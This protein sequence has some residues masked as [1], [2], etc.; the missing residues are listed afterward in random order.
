MQ[1]IVTDA[2]SIAIQGIVVTL[3]G[4]ALAALKDWLNARIDN[5]RLQRA[6][7]EATDAVYTAVAEQSQAIVDDLKAADAFTP[8]A[9]KQAAYDALQR[10][11]DI[12]SW[13]SKEILD[14]YKGDAVD[15][16]RAKIEEAVRK[17]K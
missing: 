11:Q 3:L 12:L 13:R 5:E 10:S 14:E 7:S 8:A 4:L 17:Q 9:A 16:L 15:Y 2:I 6:I 1:E